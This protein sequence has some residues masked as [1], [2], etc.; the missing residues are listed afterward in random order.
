MPQEPG[1]LSSRRGG[2][3]LKAEWSTRLLE[4][5]PGTPQTP[6][7]T[8]CAFACGGKGRNLGSY[9]FPPQGLLLSQPEHRA[10]PTRRLREHRETEEVA[11]V[12]SSG[13]A[14]TRGRHRTGGKAAR[15][16]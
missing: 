6:T 14:A 3:W 8:P 5:G 11:A 2:G 4:P 1:P 16:P 15:T 7:P 12:P 10:L 13:R 9:S